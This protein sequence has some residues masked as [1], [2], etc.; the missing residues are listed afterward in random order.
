MGSLAGV[1]LAG[2]LLGGE[3]DNEEGLWESI[4]VLGTEGKI[5]A[6]GSRLPLHTLRAP[7]ERPKYLIGAACGDGVLRQLPGG[8]R[9]VVG[10]AGSLGGIETTGHA[11]TRVSDGTNSLTA[12]EGE[13]R[14]GSI[15]VAPVSKGVPKWVNPWSDVGG[16][17]EHGW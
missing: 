1:F 10:L 11:H 15:C 13:A 6:G 9:C 14:A 7:E 16:S 2:W 4:Q 3:R 5:L 17:H 12:Q 8:A